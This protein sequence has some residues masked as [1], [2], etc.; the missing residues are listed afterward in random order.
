MLVIDVCYR[1]LEVYYSSCLYLKSF[2][3]YDISTHYNCFRQMANT[4]LLNPDIYVVSLSF[5]LKLS[6]DICVFVIGVF[7]VVVN[8]W[9]HCSCDFGCVFPI[10][11]EKLYPRAKTFDN[12]WHLN[13][14]IIF[15]CVVLVQWT[16]K[17]WILGWNEANVWFLNE[18]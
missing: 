9:C 16:S 6:N 10:V 12:I 5:R 2:V 8:F 3:F 13:N 11:K 7:V 18:D 4:I 15:M 17:H 1:P 14:F